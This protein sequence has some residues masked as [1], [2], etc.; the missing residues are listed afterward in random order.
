MRLATWKDF[1]EFGGSLTWVVRDGD[2]WWCNFA[3][4]GDQQRRTFL[5][6]F[7]DQWRERGRWT[8]PAGLIARLGRYSLSG[9]VWRN[10]VSWSPATTSAGLL[11]PPAA[12]RNRA[13]LDRHPPRPLH[14]PR[15]RRRSQDRRPPRHRPRQ[16]TR[17]VCRGEKT[18]EQFFDRRL[19]VRPE[20]SPK[21]RSDTFLCPIRNLLDEQYVIC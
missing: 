9:G 13:R 14:R 11:P 18:P 10:G 21:N 6:K 19:R 7:D 17:G 1:G 15:H 16:A 3:H 8:Y 12:R 20:T 4:Y 2:F 5:V